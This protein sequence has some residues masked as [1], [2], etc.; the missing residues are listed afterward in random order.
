MTV[1]GKVDGEP[2][3]TSA[4]FEVAPTHR[5]VKAGDA[6]PRTDNVL[7]G[8]PDAPSKAV[9]SRADDDGAVPDPE[10]HELTVAQ[11]LETGRP[12]IVVV[13]TPAFCVSR[14]CGP[15][16]DSI[17]S[18]VPRYGDRANVVHI[19]VWRDF[20]ANRLNPAASEWI[21]PNEDADPS[22]P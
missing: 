4:A 22:E 8:D 5:I 20:E 9:D 16:T 12:T 19:E 7:P 6:A 18:M 13:S 14:F 17:Q 10:L 3:V 1:R 15:I 2:V 11:A 21:Y